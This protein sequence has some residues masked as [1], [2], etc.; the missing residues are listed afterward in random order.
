MPREEGYYFTLDNA[1]AAHRRYGELREWSRRHGLAWDGLAVEAFVFP[2]LVD[3]RRAG[4][5]LVHRVMSAPQVR[6]DREFLMLYTS[7]IGAAGPAVLAGYGPDAQ[8]IAVGS[9]RRRHRRRR[10]GRLEGC[11]DQG[12]LDNLQSLD[13]NAPAPS[14]GLA[15]AAVTT[16]RHPDPRLLATREPPPT[17]DRRRPPRPGDPPRDATMSGWGIALLVLDAFVALTAIGGGIALATG[18]ER[19]RFPLDW[20]RRTPFNTYLGPGVIL[21]VAV[22]G[23]AAAAAAVIVVDETAGAL[24]SIAAAAILAGYVAVE[25]RILDQPQRWT[26]TEAFYLAVA[27]TIVALALLT[28]A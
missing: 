20:L 2:F 12:M 16:D 28:L 7:F 24:A 6:P 25:I 19:D 14:L 27:A 17:G 26:A 4:S 23:S 22:G 21:A 13:W 11:V 3:D 18:L 1:P 5:S 15:L 8:A 10:P 9:T